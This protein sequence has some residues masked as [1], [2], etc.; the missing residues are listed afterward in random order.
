MNAIKVSVIIPTY[1]DWGPLSICLDALS[2]QTLPQDRFEIIIANNEVRSPPPPDFA[3]PRNAKMITVPQHGSYAARNGALDLAEG[4]IIAFTDADCVPEPQWLTVA[5]DTFEADQSISRIAGGVIHFVKGGEWNTATLY[6]RIFMLRQDHFAAEGKAATANAFMRCKLFETVGRFNADLLTGGDHEWSVRAE[7]AGFRL[8][9]CPAAAV[10]H[11]AR[12]SLLQLL[13][14]VRR[15]AGG[16]IAQKRKR[17]DKFILPSFDYLIPPFRRGLVLLRSGDLTF[18]EVVR[19][20]A[21]LY[22]L[23]VATLGEQLRLVLFK[24]NYERR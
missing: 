18:G 24:R 8:V 11:P 17:G 4:D 5:I 12:N 19:V 23:R 13:R 21:L 10:G 16:S 9:F 7:Q 2:V 3:M 14:K 22:V 6:D 1:N 15:F 20:W